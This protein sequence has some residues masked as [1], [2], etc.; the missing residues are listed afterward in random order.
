MKSRQYK[1]EL[2]T[3]DFVIGLGRE[4]DGSPGS[5][6]VIR[7]IDSDT[8]DLYAAHLHTTII[9]VPVKQSS[10]TFIVIVFVIFILSA[11]VYFKTLWE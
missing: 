9:Y 10:N 6:Q 8:D 7:P 5:F 3:A 1:T 4:K 11:I 2:E